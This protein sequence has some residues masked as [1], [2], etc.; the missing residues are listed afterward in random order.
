MH[1]WYRVVRRDG[2]SLLNGATNSNGWLENAVAL[3][4]KQ[5]FAIGIVEAQRRVDFEEGMYA[6]ELQKISISVYSS[7]NGQRLYA[8]QSLSGSPS[9]QSFALSE[10]GDR[11]AVLSDGEISL[12]KTEMR[13]PRAHS[14]GSVH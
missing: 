14:H 3:T 9:R 12:Y 4:A 10:N 11:L 5:M 1:S 6:S 2:K 7:A 13:S 8:T